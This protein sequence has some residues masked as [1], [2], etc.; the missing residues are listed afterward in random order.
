M[1]EPLQDIPVSCASGKRIPKGRAHSK[2]RIRRGLFPSHKVQHAPFQEG[3][4]LDQ[5]GDPEDQ[6]SH[7][8]V[9]GHR[10]QNHIGYAVIN[11]VDGQASGPVSIRG[12]IRLICLNYQATT[13]A[14]AMVV[15]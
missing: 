4:F 15:S 13:L 9:L 7:L 2:G 3:G 11:Q 10:I 12:H 5:F 8:I 14:G 1:Q 6:F